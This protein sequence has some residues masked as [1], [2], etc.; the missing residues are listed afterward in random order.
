[1][2]KKRPKMPN[3]GLKAVFSGPKKPNS[4]GRFLGKNSPIFIKFFFSSSFLEIL[5]PNMQKDS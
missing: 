2:A 1:M 3:L 4:I 5:Y